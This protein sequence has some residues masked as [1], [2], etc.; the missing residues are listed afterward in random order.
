MNHPLVL[1]PFTKLMIQFWFKIKKSDAT[2]VLWK[3]TSIHM[4][5][6]LIQWVSPSWCLSTTPTH[7]HPVQ[8]I[9]PHTET[10]THGHVH[11]NA[12]TV[13]KTNRLIS[14][15]IHYVYICGVYIAFKNQLFVMLMCISAHTPTPQA[16]CRQLQLL[17]KWHHF[18]RGPKATASIKMTLVPASFPKATTRAPQQVKWKVQDTCVCLH[19]CVHSY[20]RLS[21]YV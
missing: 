17:F 9:N 3:Y 5:L 1:H 4:F 18:A 6:I 8:T 21:D 11:K 15:T 2:L 20:V 12:H 14:R 10:R 19:A 16:F 7:A 13:Q